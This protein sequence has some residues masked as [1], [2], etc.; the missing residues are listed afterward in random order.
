VAILAGDAGRGGGRGAILVPHHLELDPRVH[1]DLMARD[2]ELRFRDLLEFQEAEMDAG[3]P[4]L[5]RGGEAVEI[6]L[7]KDFIELRVLAAAGDGHADVAGLDGALPVGL[8]VFLGDA[9][10]G[11]A[12]DALARDL[13]ARPERLPALFAALGADLLMTAHAEA[14]HRPRRE[15]V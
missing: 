12:G 2:A 10:A 5:R 4:L 11:D 1:R 15:I 8:A 7:G 14:A 13:A 6:L 3:T 9:M